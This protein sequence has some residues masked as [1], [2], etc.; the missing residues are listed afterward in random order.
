MSDLCDIPKLGPKTLEKLHRLNINTSTDLLYHFPHRYLDFSQSLPIADCQP[1]TNVT[2]TGKIVSFQNIYTRSHKNIQKALVSDPSGSINLIWFNQPYLSQ[3][4]TVGSTFSFAGE[5]SL[6]QNKKTIITPIFGQYN[7]GKIIPIYPQTEGLTSNWFR[8]VIPNIP[9]NITE[10]LPPTIVKNFHLLDLPQSLFQIHNPQNPKI[11]ELARYRLSLEEILSLQSQSYLQKLELSQKTAFQI[12]K[13]SPQTDKFI[14]S[15]PFKLTPSQISA[16]Q[17]ISA[18]LLSPQPM[19]RLLQGDVGSGKTVVA[20]LA[21]IL[22]H[23]NKSTSVIIVP[24]EVLAQQH[25]QTFKALA[26]KIPLEFLTATSKV[27]TLK[28]NPIV[29]ATH[30]AIYQQHLFHQKV[31]LLIIDEQ[32]KFGVKQRSFLSSQINPPHTLT[33]TA[34]PIPRTISLTFLGNLGL[35]SIKEPPKNRLK[36]KTFLVPKSKIANCYQWLSDQIQK[37]HQQAFIVCPFIEPSETMET[38]KSAKKEFDYLQ[39][40]V[41]P[42]LKLGLIHGKITQTERQKV[43]SLFS[44]NKIN[45]LITTPIIEV[46]IDFPNAT[47]IIIQSADRFGL[48]QLHQLRGRVGRAGEQSYCYL[49]SESINQKTISRLKFLETHHHGQKIAEFDLASR[50]PGEIF[51]TIQHGFP[52]LK[53]ANLSDFE[54]I[55]TSQKIITSLVNDYPQFNLKKLIIKNEANILESTN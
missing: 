10:T 43:L 42:N 29:I 28:N 12:F 15:L 22:A 1:N 38:V 9:I 45:I 48:A 33:M 34:T 26:P 4:L 27:K 55:A 40:H 39:T 14:K 8:K 13:S 36:I 17:E 32:H 53:L 31:G 54:L 7:T 52:S 46:G 44:K 37:T 18:D 11:L 41:F 6:Y 35:T 5:I 20:I 21:C 23:F 19:N 49:F 51:S 47:T 25:L 2:I 50:G 30:A 16:W 3:T 24:T